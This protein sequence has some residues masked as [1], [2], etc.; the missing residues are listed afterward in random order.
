MI[1]CTQTNG[2]LDCRNQRKRRKGCG[3]WNIYDIL[4]DGIAKNMRRGE[5]HAKIF[6][7][8][9]DAVKRQITCLLV[10]LFTRQ[11]VYLSTRLLIY[12]FTA[13]SKEDDCEIIIRHAV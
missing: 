9:D 5:N 11:L 13:N 1:V 6:V 8:C 3:N 7:I 12:S 4:G 2:E 10:N